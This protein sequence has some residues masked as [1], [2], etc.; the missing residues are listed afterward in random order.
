MTRDDMAATRPPARSGRRQALRTARTALVA[1][2]LVVAGAYFAW[3]LST[4]DPA[5]PVFSIVLFAAELS[6]SLALLLR[7]AVTWRLATRHAPPAQPGLTVEVLVTTVDEPAEMVRRTLVAA[8][9]MDYPH[10]TW[11]LDDGNRASMQA[12]ARELGVRYIARPAN[13]GSRAGSLNNALRYSRAEFIAVFDAHHAPAR[14]FLTATLGYFRDGRIGFVQTPLDAYNLDSFIHR[15]D[16]AGA[17]VWNEQT[18]ASRVLQRGRDAC[19]AAMFGGACAVIR[20]AAL[21]QVHGFGAT[22]SNE[23]L[24][25]S[26][27]LHEAGWRS[28]YH[29]RSLAFGM[30][31]ASVGPYLARYLSRAMGAMQVWSRERLLTSRRLTVAQKAAYL[32]AV[33]GHLFGWRLAVY[34]LAPVSILTTGG[35]P[36][37]VPVREFVAAFV[38]FHL[39][40]HWLRLEIG[41][42][43]AHPL[44]DAQYRMARFAASIAATFAPLARGA[45][46][47][48]YR[49]R[50][51]ALR[52]THVLPQAAVLFASAAAVPA[53]VTLHFRGGVLPHDALVAA[54]AWA[55]LNGALAASV[56][57]FSTRV[58]A[59]RRGEYRFRVPVPAR[60]HAPN[61]GPMLGILDDVS[62]SGFRFHGPLPQRLAVGSRFNGELHLPAGVTPFAAVVRTECV[63]A[64]GGHVKGVGCT[65][66]WTTAGDRDALERYL[67]GTDLQ[68]AVNE[69]DERTPTPLE[70]IG[71]LAARPPRPARVGH[72]A[73][74]LYERT[75]NS[76]RPPHVGFISV[77]PEGGTSRR[78]ATLEPLDMRRPVRVRVVTRT[79]SRTVSG[80]PTAE[81]RV[82]TAANPVFLYT[83]AEGTAA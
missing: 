63:A 61:D 68:W 62:P 65:F 17:V 12:L 26:I 10:E 49:A 40:E 24:H 43:Y 7:L 9:G 35:L 47:G 59:F 3:R 6:A 21:D 27:R 74:A 79:G 83:M 1:A 25:T 41:H 69:L 60:M 37:D 55:A 71:R 82:E 30:A 50:A 73:P 11:L 46:T 72:W 4:L 52:W 75:A 70:R 48:L 38:G 2:Y 13:S 16:R 76:V 23:A 42:G 34:Y 22:T 33:I 80:T 19:R 39:L 20:R 29:A 36:F 51:S 18:L 54:I 77:A 14:D 8:R 58:A 32:D 28:V 45:W 64:D 5:N 78:L 53:G 44:R 81:R 66:E 56:L 15:R 67:F 31:P 57:A